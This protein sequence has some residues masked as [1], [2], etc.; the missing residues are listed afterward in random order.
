MKRKLL[1]MALALAVCLGLA[2]P[3]SAAVEEIATVRVD[4][5]TAYGQE[6]GIYTVVQDG[7]YGFFLA[8]GSQLAEPA[9][10]HAE[11][12]QDGMAV[13]SQREGRSRTEWF[14]YVD[15]QGELAVSC[16]YSK[17]FPFS[18]GRAFVMDEDGDL[19]LLDK[20]GRE[21]A[22]F[23]NADLAEG[24]ELRFSEG[25]AVIPI[26]RYGGE[27]EGEGTL[28]YLVIDQE[29]QEVCTLTDAWVDFEHGFHD[30]YVAVAES[31]LWD[32]GG[33]V[34]TFTPDPASC[35]YRDAR[36]ELAVAFQFDKADAFSDGV[37]A[38]AASDADGDT[39]Y[40]FI[41]LDG[42]YIVPPEYEAAMPC[43]DGAGAVQLDGK[44][45]YMSVEG[46]R[47][48]NF[49][50]DEASPFHEGLA[51]VRVG[52]ELQVI[53]MYGRVRFTADAEDGLPFSGGVSAM[54]QKGG[55]WGVYD[56]EG[57]LLVPFDYDSAFH[58]DGFLWLKRGDLWRVYDT[59]DVLDALEEA[60]EG[61]AAGVGEFAD[62]P[63]D[64]YYAEAVTWATDHDV[65]TGTGGGQFSPDR[66]CTTGEIIV[67]LWRAAERPEP[68]TEN[69]FTDVSPNNYYYQAALWAYEN[70][71]V[72]GGTF[73]AAAPCTR[74]MAVAYLW[75][76]SGRPESAPA[77][78]SDVSEDAVYAQ[79]V[80]WAVEAGITDGSGEGTFSPDQ[81]CSRGQIVTFLYRYLADE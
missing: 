27:E 52:R 8:D 49:R 79:A 66:P 42:E 6:D 12:F 29:G 16:F 54:R 77:Q 43:T 26:R 31:G 23:P 24:E 30:G 11:A 32:E 36:G 68:E 7:L 39:A 57:N 78:F 38:V 69:P 18:E 21:L 59:Q 75:G 15:A 60:P 48:T 55:A 22:V 62:V 33:A 71:I 2:P 46:R 45:A 19:T 61:A 34:R 4:G 35:G 58:W 56:G 72:E 41:S 9:F 64:A 81:I 73:G 44:W 47:L 74:G 53:D 20:A 40:G 80:A 37:A 5:V 10:S 28:V 67:C 3:A 14:G 76:L 13:V 1:A 70:G 63:A 25:L 50:Y 65:I 51:L 17:A